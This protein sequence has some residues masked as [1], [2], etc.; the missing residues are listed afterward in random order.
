LIALHQ[1]P[2]ITTLNSLHNLYHKV[3]PKCLAM[4]NYAD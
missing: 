1:I 3:A 4:S 2:L